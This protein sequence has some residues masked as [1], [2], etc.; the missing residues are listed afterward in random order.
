MNEVLKVV[1]THPVREAIKSGKEIEKILVSR[2]TSNS[3]LSEIVKIAKEQGILAYISPVKF[4]EI[5]D[6][7]EVA[8]N[9]NESPFVIILD[10][11]TDTRNFG[12]I[13]RTAECMGVHGIIIPKNHSASIN[14]GVIKSSAGAVLKLKI[15]RINHLQDA[16]YHLQA[17]EIK[18]ISF[19]E[20]AESNL[21]DF[22]PE[23]GGVAIILGS[24]ELGIN[25]K[26]ISSSDNHLKIEMYGSTESLNVGVAAGMAIYE[27]KNKID[28]KG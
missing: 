22:T 1:G 24:E 9:R 12:A 18:V 5:D 10:S 27:I 3:E 23:K 28:Q 25:P 13:C 17:S 11:V 16:I 20:K 2:E 14:E 8:T 26:L 4:V 6:I 7:I 15:S 21:R 19:T